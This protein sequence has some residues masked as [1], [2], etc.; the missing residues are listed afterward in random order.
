MRFNPNTKA[1][2]FLRGLGANPEFDRVLIELEKRAEHVAGEN[3]HIY[4][5]TDGSRVEVY[6][7]GKRIRITDH[8]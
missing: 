8:E 2:Q 5:F 3:P 7:T 4:Q 1:A 6:V